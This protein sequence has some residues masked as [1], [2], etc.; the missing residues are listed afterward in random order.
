MKPLAFLSFYL[1]P[2][3]NHFILAAL[4]SYFVPF[5]L[6]HG[7][8][9]NAAATLSTEY[10]LVFIPE[11]CQIDVCILLADTTLP[12]SNGHNFCLCSVKGKNQFSIL[13]LP[14]GKGIA[15]TRNI[16]SRYLLLF[17]P[18]PAAFL[19]VRPLIF[20]RKAA[21][22]PLRRWRKPGRPWYYTAL[23]PLLPPG[24]QR[25]SWKKRQAGFL[26]AL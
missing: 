14:Y 6:R 19:M 23:P 10:F 3:I 9:K 5:F 13:I 11:Y 21:A 4:K 1:I 16:G 24:E 18:G 25:Q 15:F 7:L 22:Q 17:F 12:R 26:R 8:W 2:C 20:N